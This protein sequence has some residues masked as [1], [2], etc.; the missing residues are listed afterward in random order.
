M[1]D[2]QSQIEQAIRARILEEIKADRQAQIINNVYGGGA[3]SPQS[4]GSSVRE[5]MA[6][7]DPKDYN[8]FVDITREDVLNPEGEKMGWKKR[9]KRYADPK[10]QMIEELFGQ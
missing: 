9:V 4:G 7:F 8:Y 10:E 5:A 6:Q 3:Q 1:E 2:F